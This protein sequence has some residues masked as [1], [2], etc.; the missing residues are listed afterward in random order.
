MQSK[1]K[2]G[3]SKCYWKVRKRVHFHLIPTLWRSVCWIGLLFCSQR[4]LSPHRRTSQS[5]LKQP[6]P[7]T[8][9]PAVGRPRRGS[10]F[11]CHVVAGFF[12]WLLLGH[13]AEIGF[14]A[15]HQSHPGK[16]ELEY[17]LPRSSPLHSTTLIHPD[18][19]QEMVSYPSLR[20]HRLSLRWNPYVLLIKKGERKR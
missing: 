2:I 9:R 12:H 11:S 14:V 19:K 16:G 15:S 3:M 8:H 18:T 5:P 7:A 17:P 1:I 10:W 6:S 4:E 13:P 20:G